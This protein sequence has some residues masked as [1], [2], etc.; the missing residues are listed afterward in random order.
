MFIKSCLPKW[1]NTEKLDYEND[2]K[3]LFGWRIL[4]SLSKWCSVNSEYNYCW[5]PF[6]FSMCPVAFF[7]LLELTGKR[8]YKYLAC[9]HVTTQPVL[10]LPQRAYLPKLFKPHKLISWFINTGTA[11]PT[12]ASETLPKQPPSIAAAGSEEVRCH[13]CYQREIDF[14][15][16]T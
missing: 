4:I 11:P 14:L 7:P 16:V 8:S 2:I 5:N 1:K 9:L 10:T 6:A 3:Q 13:F 12:W 15:K